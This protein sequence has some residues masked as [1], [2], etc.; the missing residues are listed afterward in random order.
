M[1]VAKFVY[2]FIKIFSVKYKCHTLQSNELTQSRN[3]SSLTVFS[4]KR[5]TICNALALHSLFFINVASRASLL[6][7]KL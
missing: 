6:K 1:E 2:S 3:H 5:S 4:S 7:Y